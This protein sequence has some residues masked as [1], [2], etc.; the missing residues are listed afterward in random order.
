MDIVWI[1][2]LAAMGGADRG[3]DVGVNT[4]VSFVSN[5]N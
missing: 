2:A 5:T 1:A 3:H 4:A